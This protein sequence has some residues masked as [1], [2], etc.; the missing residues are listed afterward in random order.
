MEYAL[1]FL[2]GMAMAWMI[3]AL[4]LSNSLLKRITLRQAQIEEYAR[5]P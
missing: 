5:K 4:L 2:F 3:E 1:F